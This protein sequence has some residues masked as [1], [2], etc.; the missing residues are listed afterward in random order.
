MRISFC[1]IFLIISLFLNSYFLSTSHAETQEHR[2]YRVLRVIDGDTIKLDNGENVRLIGIDAP[3]LRDNAKLQKDLKERH[4]TKSVELAMGRRS[5]QFTKQLIEGKKVHLEFDKKKYD[6]Y[7]RTLAYVYLPNGIFVNA[8]I[9][10]AGYAYAY[11]IK[12][13]VRYAQL[14]RQLY[15][16]AKEDRRGLW[17][18]QKNSKKRLKWF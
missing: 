18:E 15:S 13:D 10:S 17:Q 9:L 3:E 6:E 8:Q 14:F 2:L 5:Y 7:H 12:P 16:Q 4:L 1:W 11:I